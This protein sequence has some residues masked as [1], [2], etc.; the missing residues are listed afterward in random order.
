MTHEILHNVTTAMQKM[1]DWGQMPNIM[2]PNVSDITGYDI[3]KPSGTGL[4]VSA[5]WYAYNTYAEITPGTSNYNEKWQSE[6]TADVLASAVLERFLSDQ[7]NHDA[8]SYIT[9]Y[10][11]QFA[12]AIDQVACVQ[13]AGFNECF[14]K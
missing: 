7:M 13:Q 12:L 9:E 14:G 8:K 1:D 11:D 5:G 3:T 10:R 2:F 6:F 4:G